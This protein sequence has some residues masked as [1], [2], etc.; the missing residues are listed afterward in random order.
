MDSY[1]SYN[2]ITLPIY[3]SF[4]KNNKGLYLGLM[5][6]IDGPKKSF[7]FRKSFPFKNFDKGKTLEA[8]IEF[9][10]TDKEFLK[11]KGNR[12][13]KSTKIGFDESIKYYC[14]QFKIDKFP[15]KIGENRFIGIDKVGNQ[16]YFIRECTKCKKHSNVQISQLHKSLNG[17]CRDCMIQTNYFGRK[18]KYLQ[19]YYLD[20]EKTR[21][22]FTCKLTTKRI[23]Y[24]NKNI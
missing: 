15:V 22:I 6:T 14:E 3:I 4:Y 16:Y 11:I 20:K 21:M 10:K 24:F 8:A 2:G 17:L 19:Y 23:L 9:T 18:Y 7:T 1:E 5:V 12:N 13:N